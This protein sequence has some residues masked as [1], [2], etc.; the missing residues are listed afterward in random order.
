[1]NGM[2]SATQYRLFLSILAVNRDFYR[3]DAGVVQLRQLFANDYTI[4][5][6]SPQ[7]D[8]WNTWSA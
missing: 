7:N 1:M 6:L 5:K 4:C 2:S 8:Q 3:R